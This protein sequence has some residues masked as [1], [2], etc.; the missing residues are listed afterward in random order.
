VLNTDNLYLTHGRSE[1]FSRTVRPGH[2]NLAKCF[3]SRVVLPLCI[4][5]GLVPRVG[6]S[7]VTT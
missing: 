1:P 5:F 6:R 3:A 2:T 7:A 4:K